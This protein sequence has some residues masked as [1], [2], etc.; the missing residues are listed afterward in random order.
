MATA[1]PPASPDGPCPPPPRGPRRLGWLLLLAVPALGAAAVF[2]LRP[3]YL[4]GEE[5]AE[6]LR[7]SHLGRFADAEPLLRRALER[8]PDDLD[9]I[10]ALALGLAGTERLG[11]AE[12]Y[13]DRWCE[14]RPRDAGPYK[15][16]MDVRHRRARQAP[17]AA[18]RQRLME[19]ALADGQRALDLDPPGDDIA[20]E[21]VWLLTEVGRFEEADRLCRRCLRRQPD[22]PWLTYLLARV[23]R[24]R[25]A[26][27]E[28]RALLDGLLEQHPRFVQGLLLRAVLSNE[29]GEPDKA[30]PLLRQV[31]S[32][33]RSYH[34]EAY[35]QLSL[36]LARTG[37]AEEARRA[38]AEVEKDNLNTV[39]ASANNP[40]TLGVKLQR[41]EVLLATGREEE[42]VR[43]LAALLAEDPGCAPAHALLASY[44][45]RQGQPGRAAEHRR[46]AR[47]EEPPSR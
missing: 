23:D 16:R 17:N 20:P 35:Y 6:A 38:L 19:E 45:E 42:A 40:D 21:V 29:S 3:L 30:V 25:G 1:R 32:L 31:L 8:H 13:L 7:A 41:A 9:V 39:L 36:A 34:R 15:Q 4:A 12:P 2:F 18:D 37:Q 46:R 24:A 26:A 10:Q 47:R 43:L 27:G 5:R 28:A 11:E 44:Y 14:L 22:D 33:D